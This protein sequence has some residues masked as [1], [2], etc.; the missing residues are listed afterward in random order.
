MTG[1]MRAENSASAARPPAWL[2]AESS[3][4]N[5][6]CGITARRQAARDGAQ[7]GTEVFPAQGRLAQSAARRC[8]ERQN[9]ASS[10]LVSGAIPAITSRIQAASIAAAYWFRLRAS[11]AAFLS[12]V[13]RVYPVPAPSEDISFTPDDLSKGFFQITENL[14]YEFIRPVSDQNLGWDMSERRL[15]RNGAL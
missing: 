3:V 1:C 14:T 10:R 15:Y 5:H 7:A 11:A 4:T 6:G 2:C 12:A 13:S 9:D 8:R